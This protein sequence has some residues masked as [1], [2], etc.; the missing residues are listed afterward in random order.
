MFA[1]INPRWPITTLLLLFLVG[2]A[3]TPPRQSEDACSL[4]SEKGGWVDNWNRHTLRAEREFGIPQ[5]VILAT[6]WQESRFHAKARPPRDRLLGFI[7]WKRPSSAYGYPQALDSTW[8]W[9]RKD[10]GGGPL[11]RR[12]S[13]KHAAHFV[14]WYHAQSHRINGIARND[15]YNLY[16]AYHEGHGGYR[17]G[18][19]RGKPGLTEVAHKVQQMATLYERQL[20]DCRRR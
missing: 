17:R 14:G 13:F 5:H 7:P 15:T 11:T 18:T 1:G 3:S 9:Y 12:S 2:C 19:Y 16:L 10:T 20:Q 4:F 6:L 8:A